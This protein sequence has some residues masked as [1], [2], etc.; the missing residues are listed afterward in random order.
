[1]AQYI[2]IERQLDEIQELIAPVETIINAPG[3]KAAPGLLIDLAQVK[4]TIALVHAVTAA[5][6]AI[7]E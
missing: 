4:A 2:G 1:M 6:D 5:A 3:T 7:R